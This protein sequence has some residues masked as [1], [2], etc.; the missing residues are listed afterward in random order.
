MTNYQPDYFDGGPSHRPRSAHEYRLSAIREATA[1]GRRM[2]DV[3][4]SQGYFSFGMRHRMDSICGYDNVPGN[5]QYCREVAQK[6]GV[7]NV[8]FT[9][10]D[11]VQVPTLIKGPVD[12]ILYM[13]VHHH[14]IEDYGWDTASETLRGLSSLLAPDGCMIFEMGQKDEQGASM[15]RWWQMLPDVALDSGDGRADQQGALEWTREYATTASGL[16]GIERLCS[17]K[18]HGVDRWVLKLSK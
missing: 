9:Q 5:V 18:I 3:G 12:L 11:A 10:A 15:H 6:H 17:T 1:P 2:L 14:V 8:R 7:H 4:C 16:L 13:G